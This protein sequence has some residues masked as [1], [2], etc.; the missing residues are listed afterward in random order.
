MEEETV[1]STPF[2]NT[3]ESVNSDALTSNDSDERRKSTRN[4]MKSSEKVNAEQSEKA[5]EEYEASIEKGEIPVYA[6]DYSQD[7]TSESI[8]SNIKEMTDAENTITNQLQLSSSES[9]KGEISEVTNE[10]NDIEQY[11]G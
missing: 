2:C 6:G 8:V 9:G 11:L 4:K 10:I 3:M 5:F 7:C 1:C